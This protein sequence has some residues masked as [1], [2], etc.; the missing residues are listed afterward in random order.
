MNVSKL[1]EVLEEHLNLKL[2]EYSNKNAYIIWMIVCAFFDGKANKKFL[3]ERGNVKK[4]FILKKLTFKKGR[5]SDRLIYLTV[6]MLPR[7][8]VSFVLTK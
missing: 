4:L 5:E 3:S 1:D 7:I 6:I 2:Q 8:S